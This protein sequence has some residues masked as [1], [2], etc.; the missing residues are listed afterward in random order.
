MTEDKGTNRLVLIG[1]GALLLHFREHTTPIKMIGAVF[2]L[3]PERIKM[4]FDLATLDLA[5]GTHI[6]KVKAKAN[7]YRDSE[8]SNEVSYTKAPAGQKIT[9]LS[10]YR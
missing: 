5:D 1:G 4:K 8:F 9:T 2:I 6:V 3:P 10:M 7:G